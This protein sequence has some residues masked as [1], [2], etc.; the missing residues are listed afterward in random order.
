LSFT[1][2]DNGWLLVGEQITH[3]GFGELLRTTD[4]GVTWTLQAG[5]RTLPAV[6]AIHFLTPQVGYLGATSTGAW[7]TTRD[8]GQSWTQLQ[9]PT[10]ATKKSDSVSIISAP[11][12]AGDA[13][14]LAASFTTPTQGSDDGV[15]I[16]RSTNLGATWTVHLLASETATEQYSF[17]AAPDGSSFVLLRSQP[18]QDL[19][20]FTWV[21]SRSTD[22]G[23]NFT[24]TSS[25][26]NFYPG[27]LMLADHDNL[28]AI[29]GANGC[30]SF[31]TD[32]WSTAGLIASNDGGAS[33]HQVKLPS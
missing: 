16:Y 19:Q 33:W 7:W 20:T 8:A 31:K 25:V 2:P 18:A 29:G 13:V 9:L 1:D 22:G 5:Q 24:D 4:G 3:T 28:W 21:T 15:G 30:K 10:P 14:V 11:T 27:P 23:H 26:H 32:C 6:G 12:L 17:A